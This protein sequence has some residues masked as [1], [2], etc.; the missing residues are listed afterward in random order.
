MEAKILRFS[1]VPASLSERLLRAKF[2]NYGATSQF[3]LKDG[4]GMVE[5]KNQ[6]CASH[7]YVEMLPFLE[8][9]GAQLIY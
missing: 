2:S 9:R 3:T 4:E 1:N 5:Y 8:G 6:I 7:A